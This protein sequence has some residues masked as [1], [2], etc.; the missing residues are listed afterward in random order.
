MIAAYLID[1]ARRQYPLDEL[2]AQEGIEAVVEG[3]NGAA[4]EAVAVRA[5]AEA[6]RPELERLE[7]ERL[8]ED[9]A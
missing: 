1:A 8:F 2:L 7:L 9:R 3:A 4:H 6:Q 5:L